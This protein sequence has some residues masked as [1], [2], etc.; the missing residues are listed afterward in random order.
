MVLTI[1]DV[2]E[3]LIV[4]G[5]GRTARELS[6]AI[7][8][9]DGYQQRVNGDCNMLV[10]KNTIERRGSGTPRD[11]YRYYPANLSPS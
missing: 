8:G 7:F 4:N 2:L 5:P 10:W 3:F 9:S 1:Y 6:E 11:P